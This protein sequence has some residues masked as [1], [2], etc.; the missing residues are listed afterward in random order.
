MLLLCITYY[1]KNC[2][3]NLKFK[4]WMQKFRDR[5]KRNKRKN[6]NKNKDKKVH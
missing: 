2:K 1:R 5:R 4:I 3:N 6:K